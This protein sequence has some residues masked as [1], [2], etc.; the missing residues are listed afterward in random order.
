MAK[1]P[2]P[3]LSEEQRQAIKQLADEVQFAH[4]MG[5]RGPQRA[6][7]K[8]TTSDPYLHEE[9]RL[10]RENARQKVREYRRSFPEAAYQTELEK[11]GELPD[12]RILFVMKRLRS[13]D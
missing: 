2:P 10:P 1:K 6:R 12:G 3:D 9:F 5:L 8:P 7:E 4:K 13:A 11:F